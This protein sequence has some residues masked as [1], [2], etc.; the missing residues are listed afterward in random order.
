MLTVE[1]YLANSDVNGIGC[2]SKTFIPK[3]TVIW[4][5]YN[6]FDVIFTDEEFNKLPELAKTHVLHYAYYNKEHGGYVLCTD[7]AKF[8]NHSVEP[9]T[10]DEGE[11]TI[12]SEDINPG[13][14]IVSNY[15][16]FDEKAIT[17][18]I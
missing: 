12:A 1:T 2:F 5:L 13:E 17:K 7:D 6:E 4:K 11:L 8:F 15:F 3:G 18:N 10:I 16:T 9:N 14:E